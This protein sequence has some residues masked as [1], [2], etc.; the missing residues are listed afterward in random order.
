MKTKMEELLKV[1]SKDSFLRVSEK[2]MAANE[3]MAEK[4]RLKMEELGLTTL[5]G[6]SIHVIKTSVATDN[7]LFTESGNLIE[8]NRRDGGKYWYNDFNRY[9]NYATTQEHLQFAK[10]VPELLEALNEIED[11][12]TAEAESLLT[13]L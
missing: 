9:I 7:L 13:N 10:D 4:I 1:F 5:S 11:K 12:M 6:Y 8:V 2:L 3:Q